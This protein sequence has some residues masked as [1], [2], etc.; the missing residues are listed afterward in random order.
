VDDHL[1][2]GVGGEPV[3]Q[4]LKMLSKLKVVEDLAIEAH[5]NRTVLVGE[6]L[7]A[8]GEIDDA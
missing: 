6:R 3:P 8:T 4:S 7:K 5:P 2:I 1:G